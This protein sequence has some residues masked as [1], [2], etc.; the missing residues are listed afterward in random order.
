MCLILNLMNNCESYQNYLLI[1]FFLFFS[2]FLVGAGLTI[3]LVILYS[4]VINVWKPKNKFQRILRLIKKPKLRL[5][6]AVSHQKII[7][8]KYDSVSCVVCM[9]I[10]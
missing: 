7:I 2:F 8:E 4:Y 6:F 9:F 10:K 1:S 3:L 5:G